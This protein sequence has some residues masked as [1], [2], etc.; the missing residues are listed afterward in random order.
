MGL[1]VRKKS[2]VFMFILKWGILLL[3]WC[4]IIFFFYHF[5]LT[6][7]VLATSF[8]FTVHLKYKFNIYS[9]LAFFRQAQLISVLFFLF[10][11]FF[12]ISRNINCLG[13]PEETPMSHYFSWVWTLGH[14]HQKDIS[15][16]VT[17]AQSC[18]WDP[19]DA[20]GYFE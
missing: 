13:L 1:I 20:V 17:Y 5:T 4:W 7:A 12:S 10:L 9:L 16:P 11:E 14:I 8:S 19:S 2:S 15:V 3:N 18:V 6:K